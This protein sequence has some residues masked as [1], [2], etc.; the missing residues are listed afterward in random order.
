MTLTIRDIESIA[1][2]KGIE[3]LQMDVWGGDPD[4]IVPDH[5]LITAQKNGG[6]LLGAFT[7]E[8]EVVGF[9]F[10]FIGLTKAGKIKHCSHMAGVHPKYRDQRLGERLKQAQRLAVLK[11]GI[12]HVTWTFDPLE[13]RNARLNFSKLGA[14]CN[15]YYRNVYG[16]MADDVNAGMPTDRFEVDWWLNSADVVAR[17]S[18]TWSIRSEI[19]WVVVNPAIPGDFARPTDRIMAPADS[20]YLIEIPPNIHQIKRWDMALALAWR[21]Q[22]RA[23]FEAAFARG[24]AAIDFLFVDGRSYY[25]MHNEQ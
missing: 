16:E 4:M 6:L 19:K 24:Y 18:E 12:E 17:A 1:E 8:Q 14:I 23:L 9:V 5:L 20:Y 10:G 2:V 22:S 13:S 25:L 15:T 21:L 3:R 7:P 11:Q